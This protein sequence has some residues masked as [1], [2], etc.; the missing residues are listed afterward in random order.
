MLSERLMKATAACLCGFEIGL[1]VVRK[2][3]MTLSLVDTSDA[4]LEYVQTIHRHQ[5]R[6]IGPGLGDE[7][8]KGAYVRV[9]AFMYFM[10]GLGL[11][12]TVLGR[13]EHV[14]GRQASCQRTDP[15]KT[16]WLLYTCSL[17]RAAHAMPYPCL[18][19]SQPDVQ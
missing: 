4:A 1:F 8:G 2:A 13:L 18:T 10:Y 17:V 12:G 5:G 19:L 6:E 16:N 15:R 7:R 14:A 3:S 9:I 11:E